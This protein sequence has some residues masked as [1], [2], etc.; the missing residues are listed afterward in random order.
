MLEHSVGRAIEPALGFRFRELE[1][2]AART[3]FMLHVHL[4]EPNGDDR[5]RANIRAAPTPS[6]TAK[7]SA[8]P[9]LVVFHLT[10]SSRIALP[11]LNRNI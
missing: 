9:E 10:S 11:F 6:A 8:N 2:L 1:S 7:R 5:S 4:I 3:G